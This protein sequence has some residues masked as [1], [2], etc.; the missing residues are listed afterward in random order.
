[1]TKQQKQRPDRTCVL[2]GDPAWIET[3]AY[4]AEVFALL[5]RGSE[6][7]EDEYDAGRYV[8]PALTYRIAEHA[9]RRLKDEFPGPEAARPTICLD[10]VPGF[11][12]DALWQVQS[13]LRR[14]RDGEETEVLELLDPFLDSFPRPATAATLTADLETVLAVLTLDIPAGRDM[15]AALALGTPE[16]D[17]ETAYKQL[18][19]AW[20]AAGITP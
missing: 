19:T 14:T 15:A 8:L 5:G 3:A 16:F 12:L 18:V 13:V 4:L 1:M 17:F 11:E 2:P 7:A 20:K 9:I 6:I 10:V